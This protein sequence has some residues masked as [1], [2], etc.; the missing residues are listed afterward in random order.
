MEIYVQRR[1]SLPHLGLMKVGHCRAD[2][3]P[4]RRQGTLSPI[5]RWHQ[6]IVM[7]INRLV[8]YDGS[9]EWNLET[10]K[11]VLSQVSGDVWQH[12][13]HASL[14]NGPPTWCHLL[15]SSLADGL[16]GR[17]DTDFSGSRML[18]ALMEPSISR[19]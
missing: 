12:A 1:I 19:H 6:L 7:P 13:V 8:R 15:V 11:R 16:L 4:G 14:S 2:K 9:S 10:W 18:Q 17:K 5:R 3:K